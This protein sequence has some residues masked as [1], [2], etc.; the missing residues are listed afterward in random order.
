MWQRK[1]YFTLFELTISVITLGIESMSGIVCLLCPLGANAKLTVLKTTTEK[2]TTTK[3]ATT[4]RITQVQFLINLL[5][6]SIFTSKSAHTSKCIKVNALLWFGH[7][8]K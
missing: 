5:L 6:K 3:K 7:F 4:K 8:L 1:Y 2:T